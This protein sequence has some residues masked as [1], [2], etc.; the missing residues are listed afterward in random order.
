[1]SVAAYYRVAAAS[2]RSLPGRYNYVKHY[3]NTLLKGHWTVADLR[4][5]RDPL[6]ILF[7]RHPLKKVK[8]AQAQGRVGRRV[9]V[10]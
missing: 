8:V 1:M 6:K 2:T 10:A 9:P 5:S 7:A 3:N 4:V